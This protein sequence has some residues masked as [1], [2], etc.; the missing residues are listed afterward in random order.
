MPS[1]RSRL[2]NALIRHRHLLRGRLHREVFTLASSIPAFR[3]QGRESARRLSRPP[4]GVNVDAQSAIPPSG[5][6]PRSGAY[7]RGATGQALLS[8]QKAVWISS[9]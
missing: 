7:M 6:E 8:M 1:L 4:Q 9:P 5:I 3:A 2:I